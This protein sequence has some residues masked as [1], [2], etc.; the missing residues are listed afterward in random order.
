[1]SCVWIYF[2][3]LQNSMPYVAHMNHLH[4]HPFKYDQIY[5][6]KCLKSNNREYRD[7]GSCLLAWISSFQG[8][9]SR[10]TWQIR[11]IIISQNR[12]F[13]PSFLIVH[14]KRDRP[15][16]MKFSVWWC[17]ILWRTVLMS[18]ELHPTHEKVQVFQIK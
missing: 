7:S 5:F 14:T 11:R 6:V 15:S 17:G 16:I 18:M 1:M 9:F 13:S 3:E 12:N 2:L 4:L 8:I 10:F